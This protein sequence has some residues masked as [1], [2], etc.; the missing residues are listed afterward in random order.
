MTAADDTQTLQEI[1]AA[2][3]RAIAPAARASARTG[4][5]ERYQAEW[6]AKIKERDEHLAA[7]P[8]EWRWARVRDPCRPFECEHARWGTPRYIP[9]PLADRVGQPCRVLARGRNGNLL[10][11]FEDGYRVVAPRHAIRRRGTVA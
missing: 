8:H 6:A 10:I 1:C 3:G 7:W 4:L 5:A 2:A 11:E 9:H